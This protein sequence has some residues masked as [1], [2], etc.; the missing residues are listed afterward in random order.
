MNGKVTRWLL[1]VAPATVALASA[2]ADPGAPAALTGST[3]SGTPA[4]STAAGSPAAPAIAKPFSIER[5]DPA[6]DA[7]IAQVRQQGARR[8]EHLAVSVPSHCP[9]LLPVANRLAQALARLNLRP[10][11][12]PYMS[13]RGG[14]ALHDA[15]EIRQDLAI[16]VAHPVRWY[17]ALEV[18]RELGATLFIE[19]T[20]GHVSTHLVTELFPGTR[21]VS[22]T[23]QGLHYATVVATREKTSEP[24]AAVN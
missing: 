19:M 22:I 15:E 3:T 18:M 13:N 5:T 21:A 1:L 6:L 17:D 12:L 16:S 20:P 9:L 7:V 23:D 10:P 2:P 14:R 11:A 4:A 24:E 8:A